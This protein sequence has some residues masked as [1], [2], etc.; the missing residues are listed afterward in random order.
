MAQPATILLV[1]DEQEIIK[2]MEIY[3][4]NEG[5]RVLTA[6]DGLEALEQLKKEQIDL[7]ILDVMMPNMDG[8][9][10]CMK[11]REEQKMPIIMLSAKSMD[12]DKI[13][14]LSIGADDY[15]TKPFN[16]LNLL[17][18]PNPSFAGTI[19]SMKDGNTRSMNGSSMIWSSIRIHMRSGWT[20]SLFV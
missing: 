4:G 6:S 18:G 2:L 13:T 15:V 1:D 9:E 7:I 17:P 16:P 3:F 11:I 10:A 20:S 12:I 8:L 14:G 19:H 5:Y